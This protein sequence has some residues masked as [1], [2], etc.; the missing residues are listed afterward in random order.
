MAQRSVTTTPA[1]P[2]AGPDGATPAPVHRLPVYLEAAVKSGATKK[3]VVE[4][5]FDDL[6]LAL[7]TALSQINK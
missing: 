1:P 6:K 3:E 2:P 7:R 5:P 4:L